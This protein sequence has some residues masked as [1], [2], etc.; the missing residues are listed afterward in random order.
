L[1]VIACNKRQLFICCQYTMELIE[2]MKHA[3]DGMFP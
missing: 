2:M 3:T 1:D